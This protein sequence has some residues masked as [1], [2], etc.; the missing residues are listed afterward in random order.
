MIPPKPFPS[1]S[2]QPSSIQPESIQPNASQSRPAE[3]SLADRKPNNPE[4][5]Q[6]AIAAAQS[7][8]SASRPTAG[9][10]RVWT[11]AL[12]AAPCPNLLDGLEHAVLSS[13]ASATALQGAMRASFEVRTV[14]RIA[15][16]DVLTSEPVRLVARG[17]GSEPASFLAWLQLSGTA[18]IEQADSRVRL[19][20]GGISFLRGSRQARVELSAGQVMLVILS[21][22]EVAGRFPLWH[23]ALNRTLSIER[24]APAVFFDAV[25][26]LC[27]WQDSVDDLSGEGVADA[28]IDLVGAVLCL[29]APG[30]HGCVDRVLYQRQRVKRFAR[31]HLSNPEL[32]VQLIADRLELSSRQIHRL[33]ADEPM[34]LMRWVWAERLNQCH[35]ELTNSAGRRR[36][37]SDIAYAWGFND[38]A[39]FSRAYRQRFGISPREARRQAVE[40]VNPSVR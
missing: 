8:E 33:F 14:G 24:G 5:D 15:I 23:R 26:S 28:I 31:Q 37:L 20:P 2:D 9:L 25:S 11:P 32:S 12:P 4:P 30:D 7:L 13:C 27:R 34:S 10:G 18:E 19:G 16:A 17:S 35:R 29:T 40:D 1:S 39:H 22:T 38:Q 36:P 21:E 6:L 3:V